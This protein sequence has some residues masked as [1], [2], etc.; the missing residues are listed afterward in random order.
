MNPFKQ[1][2]FVLTLALVGAGAS[3]AQEA[4]PDTWMD[5]ASTKSRA[6]VKAELA[7]ARANGGMA[8]FSAGYIE[9]MRSQMT[10]AEVVAALQRAR[11][12]GEARLIDAE[13]QYPSSMRFGDPLVAQPR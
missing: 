12:S 13:G 5:I 10:R 1:V 11:I 2:P 6:E 3:V 8:V 9:P 4:T 7:Q